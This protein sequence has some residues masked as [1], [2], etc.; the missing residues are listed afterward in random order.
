MPIHA[1]RPT[2]PTRLGASMAGNLSLNISWFPPFSL[3]GVSTS[4][5]IWVDGNATAFVAGLTYYTYRYTGTSPCL[6]HRIT[7]VARNAA[8]DS[9]PSVPL[10]TDMPQGESQSKF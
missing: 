5:A 3:P 7:V 1:D 8:G 9:D 10:V 6:N 4:Y 2:P